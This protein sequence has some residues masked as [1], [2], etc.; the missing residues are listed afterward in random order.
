MV[1]SALLIPSFIAGLLTFL[2]PCTLPLVPVY[3]S[4]IGGVSADELSEP[5]SGKSAKRRIL[6][7]GLFFVLGFTAV[8]ISFGALAGV[9]G[10]NLGPTKIWLGRIGGAAVALFGLIMLGVVKPPTFSQE[11]RFHLPRKLTP[12]NPISSLIIG[13]AFAFGWTPCV[14]PILGSIL[15]FA[16]QSHT[17]TQ[18]ALLLGV[19]SLGLAIPF[20]AIA[21]AISRSQALIA[22]TIRTLQKYRAY[23]LG[24]FGLLAGFL[25][26]LALISI[27][28]F[29]G[30]IGRP[31]AIFSLTL[32]NSA[33]F[34]LPILSGAVLGYKAHKTTNIDVVAWT[35]GIFLIPLGL[36]LMTDNFGIV[37]Q[38]GYEL[39]KF[40]NYEGMLDY[41]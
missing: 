24:F 29:I 31:L 5:S 9:L 4:F 41:L 7:N 10:A 39:L 11:R 18:G 2:A 13:G 1:D 26:N 25:L 22:K 16:S 33:P 23:I 21:L 14:G 32:L 40:I 37:I 19:F 17:A 38:Y 34:V 6:L 20:L 36:L 35:G 8:F 15:L 27:G 28:N 12:G 3:L 30:A